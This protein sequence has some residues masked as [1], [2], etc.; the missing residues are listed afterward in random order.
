MADQLSTY[1]RLIREQEKAL[2]RPL[3]KKERM[4]CAK[5]AGLDQSEAPGMDDDDDD[6]P[7]LGGS[8][9][10]SD[11]WIYRQRRD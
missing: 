2:H 10:N 9:E 7:V 4:V 6:S 1:A 11:D 5:A 8:S 3:N